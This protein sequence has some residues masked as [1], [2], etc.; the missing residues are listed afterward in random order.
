MLYLDEKQV[1][2]MIKQ[3][4]HESLPISVRCIRKGKSDPR[5]GTVQGELHTLICGRKPTYQGTSLVSREDED[6]R[7]S[8]LT[9][10]ATNRMTKGNHGAWRRVNLDTVAEV[11]FKEQ[12]YKVTHTSI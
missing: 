6:D 8:T 10:W 7:C 5:Q 9:V 4:E 2:A 3:A 12:E 1:K 11:R